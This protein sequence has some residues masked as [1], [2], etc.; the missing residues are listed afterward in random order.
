MP[1]LSLV[2]SCSTVTRDC[3]CR[4]DGLEDSTALAVLHQHVLHARHTQP[5][6]GG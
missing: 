1:V 3:V 4:R 2:M 5:K 6:L